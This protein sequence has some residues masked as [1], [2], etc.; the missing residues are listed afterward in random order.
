MEESLLLIKVSVMLY[1][2]L[3]TSN[4]HAYRVSHGLEKGWAG[5]REKRKHLMHPTTYAAR[6]RPALRSAATW[7]TQNSAASCFVGHRLVWW[8]KCQR[9]RLEKETNK[10]S[11]LK[12]HQISRTVLRYIALPS[13]LW[14]WESIVRIHSFQTLR[15]SPKTT[16]A[17]PFQRCAINVPIEV[18]TFLKR[19]YHFW[20]W[21]CHEQLT[22]LRIP[23]RKGQSRPIS[24]EDQKYGVHNSCLRKSSDYKRTIEGS[25]SCKSKK[26]LI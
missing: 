12:C 13:I 8:S 10:T 25:R 1:T 6:T 22:R 17:Y 3:R 4:A 5:H 9:S 11:F 26:Y 24:T 15:H 7:N 21:L 16:S 14:A 18:C 20:H 23:T 2:A 19:H